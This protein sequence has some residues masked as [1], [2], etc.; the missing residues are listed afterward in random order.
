MKCL[1]GV[2]C[3]LRPGSWRNC[4]LC[5]DMR[6]RVGQRRNHRGGCI[7]STHKHGTIFHPEMRRGDPRSVRSNLCE[8][9]VRRRLNPPLISRSRIENESIPLPEADDP[10]TDGPARV[11]PSEARRR[12]LG[13]KDRR[14]FSMASG[15]RETGEDNQ[16]PTQRR[17]PFSKTLQSGSI[18]AHQ[19]E[20]KICHFVLK[21]QKMVP[22]RLS[23]LTLAQERPSPCGAR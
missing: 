8:G 18:H 20:S 14:R 6:S 13:K 10:A 1:G 19:F 22:L 17:D 16:H 15:Q 11:W 7:I 21:L 23:R 2:I 9:S 3:R 5:N 4:G 12:D